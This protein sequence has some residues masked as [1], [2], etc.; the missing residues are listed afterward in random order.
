[1]M[2]N[3]DIISKPYY[4]EFKLPKLTVKSIF[5]VLGFLEE[6][7]HTSYSSTSPIKST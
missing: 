1:M 3:F 7:I 2:N 6:S 5:C 4:Q